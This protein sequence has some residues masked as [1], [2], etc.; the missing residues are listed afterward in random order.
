M[1]GLNQQRSTVELW[2]KTIFKLQ[3]SYKLHDALVYYW[4]RYVMFENLLI[5]RI[6]W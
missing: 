6:L 4:Y 3:S 1:R 5:Y 2:K